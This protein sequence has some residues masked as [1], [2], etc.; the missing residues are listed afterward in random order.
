MVKFWYSTNNNNK[1][2]PI[3]KSVLIK[4]GPGLKKGKKK[5]KV[6]FLNK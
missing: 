1:K 5:K 3:Y 4:Q 2:N 6:L